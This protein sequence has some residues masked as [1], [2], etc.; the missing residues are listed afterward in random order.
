MA[1]LA[2]FEY[3]AGT[4]K[5]IRTMSMFDDWGD[6]QKYVLEEMPSSELVVWHGEDERTAQD[7]MLHQDISHVLKLVETREHL[8]YLDRNARPL[9]RGM[10]SDDSVTATVAGSLGLH[11]LD[12]RRKEKQLEKLLKPQ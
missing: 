11:R 8:A 9:L 7:Q 2:V 1:Y 3:T 4:H 6:F 12:V 5:G 10:N